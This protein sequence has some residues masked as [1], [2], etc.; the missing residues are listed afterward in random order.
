MVSL[1]NNFY[2]FMILHPVWDVLSSDFPY[3]CDYLCLCMLVFRA[4]STQDVSL[5]AYLSGFLTFSTEDVSCLY[6]HRSSLTQSLYALYLS[7]YDSF[8]SSLKICD[9]LSNAGI[10]RQ[11]T[12]LVSVSVSVSVVLASL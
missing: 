4:F 8:P 1:R 11:V 9:P 6:A 2:I 5:Y 3:L 12:V 7:L 10:N